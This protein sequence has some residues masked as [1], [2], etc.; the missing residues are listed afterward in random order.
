MG[1]GTD[2][3][4]FIQHAGISS[5]NIGF[6]GEDGGGDYHSIYD[7]YSAFVRFKDPGF[8]YGVTLAETAG[9]MF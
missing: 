1:S 5:L 4:S 7:T 6:Y 9:R 8:K 2:Y 3:S